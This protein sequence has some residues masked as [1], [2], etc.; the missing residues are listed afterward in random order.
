[1]DKRFEELKEALFS[2]GMDYIEEF[3]GFEIDNDWEKDSIENA[4]DEI[5]EQIP[6]EELETF[7]QKFCIK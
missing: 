7:Y 4:M 2:W 1:M 6:E 3:L 5:Y